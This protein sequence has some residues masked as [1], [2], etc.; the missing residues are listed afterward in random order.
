MAQSP[1]SQFLERM[2]RDKSEYVCLDG[3]YLKEEQLVK[4]AINAGS[5]AVA[6]HY[7]SAYLAHGLMYGKIDVI[8]K[9]NKVRA[10][11][12]VL[13]F[14]RPEDKTISMRDKSKKGR[15]DSVWLKVRKAYGKMTEKEREEL[16][17]SC[18]K[19]LIMEDK[20]FSSKNDWLSVML[21]VRDR[22]D[23]NINQNN[24]YEYARAITPEDWPKSL[25]IS[26]HTPKNFSRLL[27]MEDR[28]EPY[29]DMI[30]NPQKDLCDRFWE[31]VIQAILTE[32]P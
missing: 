12:Q 5:F 17:K 11:Y 15:M 20:L 18:L 19:M 32:I 27:S 14:E 8:D 22:L 21:V 4:M 2:E 3:V 30:D 23:G 16:M 13:P 6:E 25:R 26:E 10:Q 9:V 29:Y 31:I 24:I 7:L 1:L 28:K